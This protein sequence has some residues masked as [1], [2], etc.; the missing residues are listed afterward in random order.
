MFGMGGGS[1]DTDDP[2]TAEHKERA[3]AYEKQ[4]QYYQSQQK[5]QLK[6]AKAG[7]NHNI[8]DNWTSSIID[9]AIS[10]LMG[11]GVEF[12]TDSAAVENMFLD[13]P[14]SDFSKD[15]F[16][17]E[18]A[19]TGIMAGTAFVQVHNFRPHVVNPAYVDI[20]P[21]GGGYHIIRMVDKK[22]IRER[23]E[24]LESVDGLIMAWETVIEER[25]ESSNEWQEVD[26]LLWEYSFP[27]MFHIQNL[28]LHGSLYGMPLVK[29]Q[30]SQDAI[31]ATVSNIK[32]ILYYFAHPWL[33][34]RGFTANTT[35]A[36]E[37]GA[38]KM[39]VLPKPESNID[40][41]EMGGDL[42][43]SSNFKDDRVNAMHE[44][45]GSTYLDPDKM[46]A[47]SKS[48]TALRILLG[49]PLR[50]MENMR[51]TYGAGLQKL[52]MMAQILNG[53]TPEPVGVMWSDPLPR[54]VTEM[55]DNFVKLVQYMSPYAA[56][57]QAGFTEEQ[58][59]A[60]QESEVDVPL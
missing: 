19:Q 13:D 53:E 7:P 58:A 8:I 27:P 39:L 16:L 47:G 32:K 44:T 41:M 52:C 1:N 46:V 49:K 9:Q 48:G 31:N 54:N 40:L 29:G 4:W 14:M 34:G 18:L 26:R 22:W 12:E 24:P 56:A 38:G 45:N 21:D 37:T 15:R 50:T 35:E 11:G 60:M 55:I 33:I 23:I 6:V 59:Q 30:M 43:A 25:P 10:F 57:I 51:L 20:L 17:I 3:K 28:P 2:R 5:E 42:S 36:M